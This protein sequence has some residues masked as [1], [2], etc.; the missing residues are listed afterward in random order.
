MGI[1]TS[2]S[3]SMVIEQVL[4][5]E[6]QLVF[7]AFL[8]NVVPDGDVMVNSMAVPLYEITNFVLSPMV[9]SMFTEL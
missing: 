8:E 1:I 5:V 9:E 6:S 4:N 7:F 2:A 3:P